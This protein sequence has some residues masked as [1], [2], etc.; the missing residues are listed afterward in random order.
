MATGP[1][2]VAQATTPPSLTIHS[3]LTTLKPSQDRGTVN[4]TASEQVD[5]PLAIVITDGFD[6]I[7][8]CQSTTTCNA[9]VF[10]EPGQSRIVWARVVSTGDYTV[11]ASTEPIRFWRE[12]WQSEAD[13]S[14][15]GTTIPASQDRAYL[16]IHTNDYLAWPYVI[17]IFNEH[18]DIAHTCT[19]GTSCRGVVHLLPGQTRTISGGVIS[20]LLPP[21]TEGPA[22]ATFHRMSWTLGTRTLSSNTR[23][24]VASD[25]VDSPYKI[26]VAEWPSGAQV[27]GCDATDSCSVRSTY[28]LQTY[29]AKIVNRDNGHVAATAGPLTVSALSDDDLLN[30]PQVDAW[31]NQLVL[32]TADLGA[33]LALG[34]KSR[35]HSMRSSVPDSTLVCMSKG[36]K[37]AVNFIGKLG[38][39]REAVDT[40]IGAIEDPFPADPQP[41]CD[42]LAHD[43]TCLDEG[44]PNENEP[45]PEP[46]PGGAGIA[47]PP[48]CMDDDTAQVL[49]DS[50]PTQYHHLASYFNKWRE[51]FEVVTS[52][53]GLSLEDTARAWNVV[54]I[55]H[56]GPHPVEYHRWVLQNMYLA[57]QVAD[58]DA[59]RFK[60]L[61]Q[62]WVA[63]RVIADPT[64]TRLA[65]WKCR[66]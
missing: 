35:T 14:I 43:G 25:R 65:Y 22:G 6:T 8:S 57:D 56:R 48:N 63:D 54:Q 1:V 49:I 47:P 13:T 31:S 27:K 45:A 5:P 26:V 38:G 59:I 61:F 34:E 44:S 18:G 53:Y 60:Q 58:G 10:V 50:M 28:S 17:A 66:R 21:P 3:D 42:Q 55:P 39:S 12:Q 9:S 19:Q 36:A 51:A 41:D 15:S 37:A 46:D 2:S 40:L 52:R 30:S 32:T 7:K 23:A 64:L 11:H 4:V 20:R 62:E 33:C 29:T 24:F 16:T